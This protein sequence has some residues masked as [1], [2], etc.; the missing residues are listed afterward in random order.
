MTSGN[1]AE[2]KSGRNSNAIQA[3]IAWNGMGTFT[4][5]KC[6]YRA[7][8]ATGTTA[9][10]NADHIVEATATSSTQTFTLPAVSGNS[11]LRIVV[12]RTGTVNCRVDGSGAETIDGAA[13]YDIG[14][15]YHLWEGI[16]NGT[17]W[18]TIHAGAV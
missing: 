1:I 4:G 10:T 3:S 7:I 8:S 12:K 18:L 15:Q 6:A 9:L 16:C 17:Q 2:Y 11:G 14:T 13:F 5:L